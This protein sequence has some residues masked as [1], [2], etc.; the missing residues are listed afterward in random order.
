MERIFWPL[1]AAQDHKRIGEGDTGLNTGGMG[2]YSTDGS[3]GACHA[4]LAEHHVAQPVI[5]GMAAEGAPFTG[6]LYC[7]LMMTATRADGAGI[8]RTIWRSGDG[9]D[10]AAPGSGWTTGGDGGGRGRPASDQM[11]LAWRSNPQ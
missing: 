2:V 8:Q 3:A 11:K 9:S 5:D 7:G 1:P 4:R 6:V 10:S